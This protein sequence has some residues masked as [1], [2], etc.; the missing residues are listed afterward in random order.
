MDTPELADEDLRK[1][2]SAL[3]VL[4]NGGPAEAIFL[5]AKT[6]ADLAELPEDRGGRTARRGWPGRAR[7]G[8]A[9]PGRVPRAGPA[10]LP[11]RGPQGDPRL[12]DQGRRDRA[13]GGR[14]DPHR[15][16]ARVHQ[17]RGGFLRRP[18]R[19]RLAAR[20]PRRGQG[21]HRGART[22]SCATA[23]SSSSATAQHHGLARPGDCSIRS[24]SRQPANATRHSA[25]LRLMWIARLRSSASSRSAR[26]SASWPPAPSRVPSCTWD[27]AARQERLARA[28]T[29]ATA[30]MSAAMIG[31]PAEHGPGSGA[32]APGRRQ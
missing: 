5:D 10:D 16:P 27:Q 28:G 13:R 7:P 29:P 26:A 2:L 30:G 6:E 11:H 18:D 24:T 19:G 23:T 9:G 32:A 17:G 1:R 3:P 4:A 21:P 22:T 15:L 8:P 14:R 20:R 12:G 25:M 31:G